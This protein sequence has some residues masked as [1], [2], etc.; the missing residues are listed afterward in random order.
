MNYRISSSSGNII[1]IKYD[2]LD[3]VDGALELLESISSEVGGKVVM[4]GP[5][6]NMFEISNDPTHL[7]FQ[8]DARYG[9]AVIFNHEADIME[10]TALLNRHIRK[11]NGRME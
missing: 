8:W 3:E 9:L 6:N 4:V 7:R 10:V 2:D 5:H 11:L 1:Y